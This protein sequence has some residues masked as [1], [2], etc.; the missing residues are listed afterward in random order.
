[1]GIDINSILKFLKDKSVSP[2]IKILR[3]ILIFVILLAVNDYLGF[4]YY[5]NLGQKINLIEKI[6]KTKSSKELNPDHKKILIELEEEIINRKHVFTQCNDYLS[7]LLFSGKQIKQEAQKERSL[8]AHIL[9]S[10]IIWIVLFLFFFVAILVDKD[11]NDSE[12]I[13]GIVIGLIL[14]GLLA[15]IFQWALAFI[16]IIWGNSSYNYLLNAI[17][18]IGFAILIIWLFNK[19]VGDDDED[20]ED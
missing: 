11:E 12:T 3:V 6:E 14:L 1:M 13:W 2:K 18:Q 19:F 5:Y 17:I 15:F 7:Y 4:T 10:S 20:E 9:S 8:L 16:P